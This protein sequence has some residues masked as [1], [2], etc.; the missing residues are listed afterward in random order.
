MASIT[1][2]LWKAWSWPHKQTQE[3]NGLHAFTSSLYFWLMSVNLAKIFS[4]WRATEIFILRRSQDRA[5]FQL[6]GQAI[7]S[8]D[9]D[10]TLLTVYKEIIPIQRINYYYED[11][12]W[13]THYLIFASYSILF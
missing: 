2:G 6:S 8:L 3:Y 9:R 10:Y 13:M 1:G 12:Q 4:S 7:Y 5:I 11:D